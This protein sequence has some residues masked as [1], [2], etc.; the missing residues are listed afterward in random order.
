MGAAFTNGILRRPAK[1]VARGAAIHG[2]KIFDWLAGC[3][4]LPQLFLTEPSLTTQ[5][6]GPTHDLES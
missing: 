1:T 4:K 3:G 5:P 6:E 2:V